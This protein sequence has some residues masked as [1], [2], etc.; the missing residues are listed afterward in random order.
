MKIGSTLLMIATT[1]K[2]LQSC[3]TLSDPMDCSTPGSS[4]HGISQARVL[5]WGANAFSVLMIRR[6][7]IKTTMSYHLT[8]ARTIIIKKSIDS[9]FCR[10]GGEKKPFV[11]H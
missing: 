9:K 2:S 11:H 10:C 7:Q 8:L 5:E 1:A 3:P 6:I 4:I